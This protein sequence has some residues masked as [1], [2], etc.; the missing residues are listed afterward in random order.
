MSVLVDL[1]LRASDTS[2]GTT[3]FSSRLSLWSGTDVAPDA[4][5]CSVGEDTTRGAG[6]AFGDAKRGACGDLARNLGEPMERDHEGSGGSTS[7]SVKDPRQTWG[8]RGTSAG[9]RGVGPGTGVRGAFTP[10]LLGKGPG[11]VADGRAVECRGGD[12]EKR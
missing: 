5:E 9:L 7:L 4:S 2:G 11:G 12:E 10:E 6:S 8:A 3:Q 1:R